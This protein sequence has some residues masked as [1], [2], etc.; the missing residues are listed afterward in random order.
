MF[1]LLGDT[2][3]LISMGTL[4]LLW[5]IHVRTMLWVVGCSPAF[6]HPEGEEIYL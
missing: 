5:G 6:I 4:L 1:V 2:L 3:I